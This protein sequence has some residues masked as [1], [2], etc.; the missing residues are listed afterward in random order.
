M[1]K[2]IQDLQIKWFCS[3]DSDTSFE[4]FFLM[5][6]ITTVVWVF[7]KQ[8]G[9]HNRE[10]YTSSVYFLKEILNGPNCVKCG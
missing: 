7:F 3:S 6:E 8:N 10:N 2:Y 5:M 9:Q 1:L 4:I